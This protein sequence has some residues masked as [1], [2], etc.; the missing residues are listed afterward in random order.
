MLQGL[1]S[2]RNIRPGDRIE[3][4]PSLLVLPA[5][6]AQAVLIELG[7]TP[8][9]VADPRRVIWF[10]DSNLPAA[11]APTANERLSLIKLAREI[12]LEPGFAAAGSEV[13]WLVH[14]GRL[15]P[16]DSC[17]GAGPEMA[18]VGGLSALGLRATY[19]DL[20]S[21]LA[22]NPLQLTVPQSIKVQL[23]GRLSAS[24]GGADLFWAIVNDVGYDNLA[25]RALEISGQGLTGLSL[26]TRLALASY[27]A[28]AGLFAVYLT[29]DSTL[30]AEVNKRLAENVDA[31][32][33]RPY[34]THAAEPGAAYALSKSLDLS[35][36][37]PAVAGARGT[38]QTC[39][40]GELAGERINR[41]I[42]GGIAGG[43]VEAL[44]V[45]AAR[46]KGKRAAAGVSLEILPASA[47][48]YQAALS[49][50]LLSTFLEAGATIQVPGSQTQLGLPQP[51]QRWLTTLSMNA[52]GK[53]GAGEHWLC[54]P[55]TA[56]ASAVAGHVVNPDSPEV[57][58]VRDSKHSARR[59]R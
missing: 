23:T 47:H 39:L 9:R 13:P 49:D 30:V 8:T 31:A 18:T 54:S 22:G 2:A 42:I 50:G 48:A 41:V 45:V 14:S 36:V 3:V 24:T 33:R 7:K 56:I 53:S 32:S 10:H 38:G 15:L 16:G 57:F 17:V 27:A 28:L 6:H 59:T 37:Q 34:E 58:I 19:R 21:M 4:A 46:L 51:S 11:D 26:S 40:A 1:S 43:T 12:G 55:V 44:R 5:R 25:G 35:K 52:P 29:P 20:A